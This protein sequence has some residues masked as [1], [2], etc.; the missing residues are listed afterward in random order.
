MKDLEFYKKFYDEE[1]DYDDLQS[2]LDGE[3]PDYDDLQSELDGE[4]NLQ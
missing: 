2:E 1:P 3:E 4:D